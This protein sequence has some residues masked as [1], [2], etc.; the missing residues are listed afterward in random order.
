MIISHRY[1]GTY[2][3]LNHAKM[4]MN[5]IKPVYEIILE[6]M[7]VFSLIFKQGFYL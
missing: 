1:T 7:Y 2:I 4:L 3:L 6:R 5:N